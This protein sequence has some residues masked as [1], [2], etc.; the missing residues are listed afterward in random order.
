ML[1][2]HL[3]IAAFTTVVGVLVV[4]YA[5]DRRRRE[6]AAAVERRARRT[7]DRLGKAL[8]VARRFRR[9][10]NA[11]AAKARGLAVIIEDHCNS[12]VEREEA[13]WDVN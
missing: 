4:Y 2:R 12:A 8:R 7:Y 5:I 9:E 1:R 3:H 11:A 10:R 13:S 6:E